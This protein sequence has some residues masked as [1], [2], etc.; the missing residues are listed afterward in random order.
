MVIINNNNYNNSRYHLDRRHALTPLSMPYAVCDPLQSFASTSFIC[1]HHPHAGDDGGIGFGDGH[2]MQGCLCNVLRLLKSGRSQ[3]ERVRQLFFQISS[4]FL[5][6]P[7]ALLRWISVRAT[8][9]F[10]PC[11]GGTARAS[12]SHVF[13]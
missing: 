9:C 1:S 8:A 12:F 13:A 10:C 2:H 6:T 11:D 4:V 5:V 7:V 3:W